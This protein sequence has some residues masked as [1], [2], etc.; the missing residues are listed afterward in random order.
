MSNN[1]GYSFGGVG[2]LTLPNTM[3]VVCLLHSHIKRK[4]SRARGEIARAVRDLAITRAIRARHAPPHHST[5]GQKTKDRGI[6]MLHSDK[7][8]A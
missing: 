6:F 8:L 7:T 3:Q 5:R 1:V 4:G 2:A